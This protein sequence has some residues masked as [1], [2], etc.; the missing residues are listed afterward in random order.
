MKASMSGSTHRRTTWICV[1]VIV[2]IG[3]FVASGSPA[4]AAEK[5]T[6]RLEWK[7]IGY[8]LPFYWAKEKGYYTQE[9][10]DL[11]V[12]EGAGSGTTVNAIGANADTFGYADYLVMARSISKGMPVKAIYGVVQT[13]AWAILSYE[14]NAIRKPQD[15]VGRSISFAPDIRSQ[16][17]LWLKINNVPPDKVDVRTVNAAVMNSTFAEKKV[18]ALMTITIGSAIEWF[19]LPAMQGTGK[20]IHFL[21]F[22][23]TGM[24]QLSYGLLVHNDTIKNNPDLIRRFLRA[25]AKG[26]KEAPMNI[27]EA[28]RI[29]LKHAPGNEKRAEAVKVQLEKAI[30]LLHTP[31]SKGKPIGWMSEP[32]WSATRDILIKTGAI[33]QAP[34]LSNY[35]T[36]EFVPAD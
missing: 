28:L 11:D 12:K 27:T 25:T 34:P 15:L 9:G 20:P 8:H 5:A 19:V 26:W 30:E 22:Q 23:D 2:A 21:R 17:D 13:S 3:G 14:D 10:I 7:L 24:G 18:D 4:A 33:T 31:A 16:F 32:D 35:Y 29:A 36:N 1:L 6:L